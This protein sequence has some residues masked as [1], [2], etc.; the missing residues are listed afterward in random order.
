VIDKNYDKKMEKTD[1]KISLE[2]P[3]KVLSKVVE[4]KSKKSTALLP[5][6]HSSNCWWIYLAQND[7]MPKIFDKVD[8]SQSDKKP[9]NIYKNLDV[10]A[11][12]YK[13]PENNYNK[14]LGVFHFS[15]AIKQQDIISS[16]HML[17][18]KTYKIYDSV[19]LI[20]NSLMILAEVN[21][22]SK[23]IENIKDLNEKIILDNG[24][25]EISTTSIIGYY[26][27]KNNVDKEHK[28]NIISINFKK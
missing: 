1:K 28:D 15:K 24:E 2:S 7:E 12:G 6:K 17:G 4:D 14:V 5:L 26:K 11:I 22:T 23:E 21:S 16:L 9:F 10:F 8:L 3:L 13:E 18:V 20:D 19:A 25:I 27:S